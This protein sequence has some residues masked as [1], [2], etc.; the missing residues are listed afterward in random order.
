MN[1]FKKMKSKVRGKPGMTVKEY[2]QWIRSQRKQKEE[3]PK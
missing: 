1:K 2:Y 3:L